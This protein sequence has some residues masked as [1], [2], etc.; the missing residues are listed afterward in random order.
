MS[1]HIDTPNEY[2]YHSNKDN[3]SRDL[4]LSNNEVSTEPPVARDAVAVDTVARD[5]VVREAVAREKLEERARLERRLV[6]NKKVVNHVRTTLNNHKQVRKWSFFD[7]V[8]TFSE[9]LRGLKKSQ[10]FKCSMNILN[11]FIKK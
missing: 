3:L 4:S 11:L 6:V 10:K 2:S 9:I 7:S 8:S 5:A 1:T